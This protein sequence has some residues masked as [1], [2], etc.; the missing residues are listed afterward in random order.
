MGEGKKDSG[1]GLRT[2]LDWETV[3]RRQEEFQRAVEQGFVPTS[4]ERRRI[5]HDRAGQLAREP[6]RKDEDARMIEVIEFVLA[7]ERYAF[8]SSFVREVHPLK[9]FTP[10]PCTPP[11]VL[12]IMNVR[13]QIIS[14]VD[15]K[16][17]FDLPDKGLADLNRVIILQGENIAFG[18]LADS[19]IGATSL[20]ENDLQPSL[21]TLTGVREKYLKGL[22]REGTVIL[23]AAAIL[24][25]SN[26]IVNEHVKT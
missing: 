7:Y 19:I 2:A 10:L 13:G 9:N 20:N 22:T 18:V 26:I 25:D 15:L 1:P 14:I 6:E 3:R 4:D 17:F 21:P 16:R 12:G 11:F 5:L 23:E 24:S 8:E